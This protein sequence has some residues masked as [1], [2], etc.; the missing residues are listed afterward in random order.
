MFWFHVEKGW[1]V[2]ME[3]G[4]EGS[5]IPMEM[6][7]VGS[8]FPKVE[9]VAL[10]CGP[11]VLCSHAQAQWGALAGFGVLFPISP[12]PSPMS[13]CRHSKVAMAAFGMPMAMFWGSLSPCRHNRVL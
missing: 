3:M 11:H 2:P 7:F 10:F 8:W 5:W 12:C 13:P 1:G 6:G 4:L 9:T